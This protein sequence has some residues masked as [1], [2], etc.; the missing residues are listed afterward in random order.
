MRVP[1]SLALIGSVWVG[2]GGLVGLAAASD[3]PAVVL[4]AFHIVDLGFATHW[5]SDASGKIVRITVTEVRPGSQAWKYG[6]RMNDAVKA[7]DHQ[8]V[9][10]MRR[11][12]YLSLIEANWK[13]GHPRTY[14]FVRTRGFIVYLNKSFDLTWTIDSAPPRSPNRLPPPASGPPGP[15]PEPR[16]G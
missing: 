11:D 15:T 10:G 7:I 8:P 9:A 14:T 5:E 2:A 4:P 16:R 12:D 3:N 6:L 13:L 1:L